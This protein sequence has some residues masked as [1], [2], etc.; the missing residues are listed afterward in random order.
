MKLQEQHEPRS[1]DDNMHLG[2]Y[3]ES[4]DRSVTPSGYLDPYS[5]DRDHSVTPL[6]YLEP[7]SANRDHSAVFDSYES[8]L[9]NA[10]FIE[11]HLDR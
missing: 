2:P 9:E 4:R 7:Y 5:E 10:A 1:Y 8:N 11:D 6:G 3:P